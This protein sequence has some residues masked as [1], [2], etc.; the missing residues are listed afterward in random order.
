MVE[1]EAEAVE[2]VEVVEV[3][4][5]ELDGRRGA[6][7]RRRSTHVARTRPA[8]TSDAGLVRRWLVECRPRR[9]PGLL[10]SVRRL[11]QMWYA[12]LA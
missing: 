1:I 10:P 3:E 11:S 9:G 2:V 5:V 12:P 6:R 7:L 8:S 4:I